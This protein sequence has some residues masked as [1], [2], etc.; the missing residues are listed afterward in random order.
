MGKQQ[1]QA[2]ASQ[3]KKENMLAV[4]IKADTIEAKKTNAVAKLATKWRDRKPVI[5]TQELT[6]DEIDTIC[7]NRYVPDDLMQS[8]RTEA[9][10]AWSRFNDM[11][12][13]NAATR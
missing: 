7:A 4:E 8:I 11:P 12:Y 6:E 9:S 13:D 5:I 3:V 2:D 10:R 1:I